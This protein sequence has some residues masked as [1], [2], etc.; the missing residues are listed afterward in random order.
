M[1]TELFIPPTF[2]KVPETSV[3]YC[4]SIDNP[5]KAARRERSR[6][7]ALAYWSDKRHRRRVDKSQAKPVDVFDLQGNFVATYKSSRKAAIGLGFENVYF[8]ERCIRRART[9]SL[10]SYKGYQYRD[11]RDGVTR[12]EPY[13]RDHK[14]SGYHVN[15][16]PGTYAS[17]R[18]ASVCE[19][20]IR[21]EW[22]SVKQCAEWLG[23]SYGAIW[24]AMKQNR[25]IKGHKLEY[26]SKRQLQ[27]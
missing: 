18:I 8:A 21:A 10:K 11:H 17:R 2:A 13:K 12:I 3:F 19:F 27:S 1:S 15:R 26:Q 23:V 22:D 9:G 16:R 25:P 20:G 7:Q 5:Q 4:E 24:A 6:R 14:P